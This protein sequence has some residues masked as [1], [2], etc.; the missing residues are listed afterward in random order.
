VEFTSQPKRLTQRSSSFPWGKVEM[1]RI[2]HFL[3]V[4]DGLPV[5]HTVNRCADHIGESEDQITQVGVRNEEAEGVSDME[6]P[7]AALENSR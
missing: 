4:N 3:V 2:T 1:S 6:T 7:L 5:S